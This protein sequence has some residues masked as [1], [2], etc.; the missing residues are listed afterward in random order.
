MKIAEYTKVLSYVFPIVL[1]RGSST[2]NPLLELILYRNQLQLATDD[3]LYSD[4]KRYKPL[5]MAFNSVKERLGDVHTVLALGTGI[6]SIVQI[7]NKM[8]QHPSFTLVDKDNMIIE[9]A[10]EILK[11][12]SPNKDWT[13]VCADAAE[14]I[15][16]AE[17]KYDMVV[18]DIFN[19][20]VVP[21]FVT[22]TAFLEKCRRR[23]N[24]GGIF[25][26]NYIVSDEAGWQE[27][28]TNLEN[29]FHSIRVLSNDMNRIILA[30]A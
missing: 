25:I 26:L 24:P 10:F 5:V 20:R 18:I 16:T 17:Q 3:A 11:D 29:V 12:V 19:S 22:G 15:D 9:W 8:N 27:V 7:L 30:T 6:G 2:Y 13:L 23:L 14:Y 1:R 4:G 28:Y 21:Q